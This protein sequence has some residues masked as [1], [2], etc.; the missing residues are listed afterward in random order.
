MLRK[1]NRSIQHA[2]S[3]TYQLFLRLKFSA[4]AIFIDKKALLYPT[5]K[6]VPLSHD[7]P[8]IRINGHTII[9]G[10]LMTFSHGGRVVI[11]EYCIVGAN[12]HIWSAKSIQIGDRVLISHNVNIFDSTTHPLGAAERHAQFRA[13]LTTGHPRILDLDEKEIII[14]N[15]ALICAGAIILRG[16]TIGRGAVV[17]AGAI[18]TKD[19]PDFTIVAGNPARVIRELTPAA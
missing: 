4:G 5:A 18:V 10:E 11:G 13:I 15:D 3:I 14:K 19:V 1:L 7:R 8:S 16:V 6:L 9:R 12:T 17:A 2:R